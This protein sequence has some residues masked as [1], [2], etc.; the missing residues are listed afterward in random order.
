MAGWHEKSANR[1]LFFC[2]N[3]EC[4]VITFRER[5]QSPYPNDCPKC[6]ISGALVRESSS[7]NR[8][9]LIDEGKIKGESE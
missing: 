2:T 3:F 8:T 1:D 9:A 6:F 7:I 5:I 4:D